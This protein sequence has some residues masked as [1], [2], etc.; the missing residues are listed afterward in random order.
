MKHFRLCILIHNAVELNNLDQISLYYILRHS[1][2]IQEKLIESE[3][4][5]RK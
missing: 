1:T 3:N 4:I 2:F 5:I